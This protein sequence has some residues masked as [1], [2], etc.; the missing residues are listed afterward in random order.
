MGRLAYAM[1]RGPSYRTLVAF[2]D[3]T[4]LGTSSQGTST[5]LYEACAP[6]E[7]CLRCDRQLAAGKA[8]RTNYDVDMR[9][10]SP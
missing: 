3:T 7:A 8:G 1:I 4:R 10:V 6:A 9:E 5:G 2:V